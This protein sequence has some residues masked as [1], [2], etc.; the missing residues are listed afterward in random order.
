MEKN[1]NTIELLFKEAG[2]EFLESPVAIQK[3]LKGI[4]AFVFDWDG[5]FNDGEKNENRSSNFN[6]ADSMGTNLLR[7]THYRTQGEI[8]VTAIISGE[9]NSMS[10]YFASRER[11]HSCY[12]KIG[13]K[14]E[15]MNHLCKEHELKP[16]QICY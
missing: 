7:Y 12:F 3:K 14:I 9:K 1:I 6:E 10:F 4:K 8:P 16:E 11:F 13:N 15:A 2:A 5:V